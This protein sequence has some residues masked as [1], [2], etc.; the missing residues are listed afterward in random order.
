MEATAP[1][2]SDSE[3]ADAAAVIPVPDELEF[4]FASEP[5]PAREQP[6]FWPRVVARAWADTSTWFRTYLL[7]STGAPAVVGVIITYKAFGFDTAW[8]AA[9]GLGIVILSIVVCS[10][11]F[12]LGRIM[13][14]PP[15][16]EQEMAQNAARVQAALRQLN[17]E[18]SRENSRIRGLLEVRERPEP[19]ITVYYDDDAILEVGNIC[20]EARFTATAR[21]LRVSRENGK[22]PSAEPYALRWCE[23]EQSAMRLAPGVYGRLPLAELD[24]SGVTLWGWGANGRVAVGSWMLNSTLVNSRDLHV[25][26][27]VT[28]DCDSAA[29]RALER[30]YELYAN[31]YTS[32]IKV[33]PHASRFG[34]EET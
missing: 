16:M 1:M 14:L 17:A 34:W 6:S 27:I 24:E 22:V 7:Q 29:I 33:T 26:M 2:E 12:F 3:R 19:I 4:H 23:T 25:W 28:L 32:K 5:V 21:V 18:Q 8:N 9:V 11:F 20:G 15:L 13:R 30:R 31:G 10:F